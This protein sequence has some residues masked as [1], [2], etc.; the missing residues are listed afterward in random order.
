[1]AILKQCQKKVWYPS[2]RIAHKYCHR[3][4][5]CCL[6]KLNLVESHL[7]LNNLV[8]MK[9]G[10]KSIETEEVVSLK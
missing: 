10:A 5:I 4:S 1:M 9:S 7:L 8:D 3:I 6:F 2:G